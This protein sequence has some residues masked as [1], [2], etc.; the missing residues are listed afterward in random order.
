MK[1]C[2]RCQHEQSEHRPGLGCMW[3]DT[4]DGWLC[5]CAAWQEPGQ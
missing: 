5:M 2:A 4:Q 1:Q 3:E